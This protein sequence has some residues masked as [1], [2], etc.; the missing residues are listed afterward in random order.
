MLQSVEGVAAVPRVGEAPPGPACGGRWWPASVVLTL[1]ITAAYVLAGRFGLWLGGMIEGH[2]SLV[3]PPTGIALAAVWIH[4]LRAWPGL[5]LGAFLTTALPDLM[6]LASGDGG[7]GGAARLTF[8][9]VTALGNPLPAV[10]TM[11]VLRRLLGTAR[12]RLET[13]RAAALLVLIGGCLTPAVSALVGTAGLVSTGMVEAAVAAS[14]A[15]SW[16]VGDAVG[17]MVV[18]TSLIALWSAWGRRDWT[19]RPSEAA[20]LAL[21]LLVF[22]LVLVEVG[23]GRSQLLVL[24]AFPL[25]IWA[26]VR[27]DVLVTTLVVLIVDALSVLALIGGLRAMSAADPA[28][29][30]QEVQLFV[31]VL[32]GTG[33]I[34]GVTTAERRRAKRHLRAALAELQRA[35]EELAQFAYIATHDLQEPLRTIAGF[36]ELI[37]REVG[38]GASP[39][40]VQ[41]ADYVTE[42]VRRMKR[43]FHGLMRFAQ[44]D[45]TPCERGEVDLDQ[46][47]VRAVARCR[48]AHPTAALTVDAGPL[49]VVHGSVE[50]FVT[51]FELLIDNAVRFAADGDPVRVEV[52]GQVSGDQAE[53]WVRDD[54]RGFDADFRRE[55]F[56]LFRRMHPHRHPDG[57]GVGLSIVHR[58]VG[59]HGGTIALIAGGVGA[60]FHIVLPLDLVPMLVDPDAEEAA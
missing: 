23:G 25:V 53:L 46:A 27:F 24:G 6:A 58:I 11:L 18:G 36:T 37:V 19:G 7:D 30:V 3:W 60:E 21:G 44:V 52:R 54:G 42:G 50:Q 35:H 32:S 38:D 20:L 29:P 51:L 47:L 34:L 13:A 57:A 39:R 5:A 59:R 48:S 55:A 1:A 22:W 49:P 12:P 15:W 8:A 45:A 17:A 40:L 28:L 41:H 43:Q 16:Y 10:I 14:V 9:L 4:G 31:L 2:V 26:A 33:L 56:K